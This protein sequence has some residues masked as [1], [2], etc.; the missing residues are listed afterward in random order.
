MD[1]CKIRMGLHE[2]DAGATGMTASREFLFFY[3]KDT[4]F[5]RASVADPAPVASHDPTGTDLNGTVEHVNQTWSCFMTDGEYVSGTQGDRKKGFGLLS[6]DTYGY[7][8]DCW[9]TII[10]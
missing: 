1:G 6:W 3:N 10:D 7:R 5:W 4:G 2:W 9:M 8:A